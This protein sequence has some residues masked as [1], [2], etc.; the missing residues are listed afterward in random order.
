[1]QQLICNPYGRRI[2]IL[3]EESSGSIR[4]SKARSRYQ[5]AAAQAGQ[6]KRTCKEP[7]REHQQ[8]QHQ[9]ATVT[10]RFNVSLRGR[11]IAQKKVQV[12]RSMWLV[13][14]NCTA[15]RLTAVMVRLLR[16]GSWVAGFHGWGSIPGI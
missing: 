12:A 10:D 5:G 2:L 13:M 1:M 3:F 16:A 7:R 6:M 11:K 15:R 14:F 4:V 9:T 8:Q